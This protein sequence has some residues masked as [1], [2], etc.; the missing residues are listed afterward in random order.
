MK[1]R[2]H[3]WLY[4]VIVTVF[5]AAGCAGDDDDDS[6]DDDAADDDGDDDTSMDDDTDDDADDDTGGEFQVRWD[7]LLVDAEAPP[8]NPETGDAT[9]ALLNKIPLFRFRED[10]G[11]AEPRPV[12]AIVFLVAGYTAGANQIRFIAEN[13]VRLTHGDIEVWVPDRRFHL[14]EDVVGSNTAEEQGDPY[15]AYNYY[16]NGL[17]V[18]GRTFGGYLNPNAEETAMLSEWGLEMQ[19]RDYQTLMN[20]IPADRRGTNVFFGGHSRGVWFAQAFAGWETEPGRVVGNDLAGVILL[21]GAARRNETYDEAD[22]LS[23]VHKIRVG[24]LPR[25]TL[26]SF[27]SPDLYTFLEIFTMAASDSLGDQNDPTLGPDGHFPYLGPF[28]ILKPLM[29]RGHNVTLTNEAFVGLVADDEYGLMEN[30]HGH[31]GRLTGGQICH[32]FLGDYPCEDGA[33]YRWLNY[34]EVEPHEL[35]KAQSLIKNIYEGPSN[36]ADPYYSYRLDIDLYVADLCDTAGSWRDTYFQ[37]YSSQMDAPVYVM[38]TALVAE[39]G[40]MEEYRDQLPPVRGYDAPRT[41]VGYDVLYQTEWE[42]ID[43]LQVEPEYN[44]FFTD[45]ADWVTTWSDGEVQ[46]PEFGTPWEEVAD[47]YPVF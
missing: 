6:G 5:A 28:Q 45:L 47:Q 16:Y 43:G 39:T 19:L 25:T 27:F 18:N 7:Y 29:T 32:D 34:D 20:L 15:I 44:N 12:K 9:P 3:L 13:L 42:H 14:L 41:E 36:N 26:F 10:V 17:E 33:S 2:K 35:M 24:D 46:V 40:T 30:F 1:A 38:A 37:L 21:D 11:D 31:M 4:L 22:Y 23:D 8:A